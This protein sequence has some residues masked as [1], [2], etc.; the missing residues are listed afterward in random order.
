MVVSLSKGSPVSLKKADGSALNRVFV[1]LGWDAADS[2]RRG[3]FGGRKTVE[4]DL[5]AS[6][7]L[8][9]ANKNVVDTV[10]YSRLVSGDGSIRHG[11]DNLTGEGDGDDERIY[12]N[13]NE[14]HPSVQ[15]IVFVISS[16]SRQT[17][18]MIKNVYARVV[19][20]SAGETEVVRY[21]L[22]E[23]GNHTAKVVAK[24]YRAG[25]GWTIEALGIPANGRNVKDLI[26]DAQ[27]VA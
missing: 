21:D 15:T 27:A 24:V 4:I 12:V 14:V 6:A 23:Q 8:L 2:G 22:A 7:V 18:D 5:D 1:G 11:G 16:Y 13:L 10:W 26:A 19:D 17:F 20:A 9:D 3:L 25:N